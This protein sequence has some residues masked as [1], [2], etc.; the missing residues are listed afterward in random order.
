[1]SKMWLS[2]V[3]VALSCLATSDAARDSPCKVKD[4]VLPPRHW[5]QHSRPSPD[6][7]IVLTIG[8][9]QPNFH[10]LEQHL[11]QV[12]DPDHERYGDHLS[13]AQVDALVAPHPDSLDSVNEWL[14]SYGISESAVSRSPAKDWI[15]LKLPVALVEKMLDTVS[16]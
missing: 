13:K 11:Y 6:H 7:V 9:P 5:T 14:A 1:M 12:S 3:L 16:V 15:R 10:V 4:T 2:L 8:L